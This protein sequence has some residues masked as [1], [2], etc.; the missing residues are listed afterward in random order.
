[1]KANAP[2]RKVFQDALDLLTEDMAVEEAVAQNKIM[3][4]PIEK[5]KPFHDHPFRLY[6]GERLDDM[7]ES[8]REHG[9]LNPVIVRVEKNGYEMLAGHNRANAARLAG[10]KE[11]PAIVKDG[12]SEEDAYVYVIETNLVQRSF[13]DLLPSEKAA[14]LT[15][16][17]EKISSQGKRNDILCE[18]AALEDMSGT[19]GHDVHKSQRSRDGLGDE[20]GMTGRNIARY[21]RLDKLIPEFKTA[22]DTGALPLVAAV[23][24]SYLSDEEQKLIHHASETEGRKIQAK[25]AA[26]FRKMAG[27]ITKENAE[28]AFRQEPKKQK[29]M[30]SVKISAETFRRYFSD[31]AAADVPDILEK[32]LEQYFRERAE[33]VS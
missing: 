28:E 11:I 30:V 6:E 20:Y 17:Y 18:I 15:E 25:Q 33:N 14:V 29:S 2:K 9:I 21:M 23:D 5:L 24:L 26:G 7:V 16:R 4:L 8:I 31:T 1:M 27:K 10:L 13:A 32:A 12:L 22:V 19:C 3:M